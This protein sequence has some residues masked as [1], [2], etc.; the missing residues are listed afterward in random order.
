MPDPS[1]YEQG[2][3]DALLSLKATLVATDEAYECQRDAYAGFDSRLLNIIEGSI[4]NLLAQK[5]PDLWQLFAVA[6]VDLSAYPEAEALRRMLQAPTGVLID[7][8]GRMLFLRL[9]GTE[10]ETGVLA[11]L[12]ENAAL[13]AAADPAPPPIPELMTISINGVKFRVVRGIPLTYDVLTS[14]I[15]RTRGTAITYE[16]DGDL[17]KFSG[18][19]TPG[20][21]LVVPPGT[22]FKI[23]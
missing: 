2:F 3:R 22:V 20:G 14:L 5:N 19:L 4:T 10:Y 23:V 9:N 13:R 21:E 6:R 18:V 12:E 11:L 16:G 8:A 7:S 17:G 15:G 1:P